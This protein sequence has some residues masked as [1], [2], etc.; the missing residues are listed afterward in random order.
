MRILYTG[1]LAPGETCE[2]RRRALERLGH[3]TVPVDWLPFVHD[4]PR[5]WRRVQWRLRLGPMIRRYNAALLAALDRRPDLL[6]VD[7]GLFV[8]PEVLRTAR[9]AGV[10]RLVHYSPDNYFLAQ[11]ASRHLW[12]GLPLYDLV[13]TTKPGHTARLRRAGARRVAVSGNAY[14]P[15][16]HRPVPLS[17]ADEAAFGC[18][19]SFIG[20]WEPDRERLLAALATEPVRLS[21]RGPGWERARDRAVRAHCAPGAVLG[22]DY[23]RA[24]GAARIGLGLLSRLAG[25]VITQRSIELP[26]CGAFMLAER[27]A[28]HL[29]HFRE[30]EE[31]VFFGDA[32]ELLAKVRYY[33]AH[34]EERRRIATAGRARCE[35]SAY[36]YDARL[37]QV[38]EQ[39]EAA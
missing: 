24:L 32:G 27:T 13:V 2:M 16:V 1:P 15:E 9:R 23:A 10:G 22:D 7:K 5:P 35:R 12:A 8:H 30:D 3:E 38:L 6:W 25:D 26:A 11:N 34:E 28:E 31:A 29:A 18:D 33:L 14:D 36:S 21:I 19:V 37:G 4:T 20:R 39:L 17:R